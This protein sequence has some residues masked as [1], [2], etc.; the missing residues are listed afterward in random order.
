MLRSAVPQLL[1][2]W[3]YE[4]S[5]IQLDWQCYKPVARVVSHLFTLNVVL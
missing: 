4:S 1:F 3:Q 5:L 2:T